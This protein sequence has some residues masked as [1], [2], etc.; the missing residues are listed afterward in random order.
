MKITNS[1]L[2]DYIYRNTDSRT[3]SRANSIIVKTIEF[4]ED[5][6]FAKAKVK[7]SRLY[8]VCFYGLQTGMISSSCTCPFDWGN[9][10]KH[11]V[12]LANE[13]DIFLNDLKKRKTS[14]LPTTP[15][16]KK[17]I[18]TDGVFEYSF[19]EIKNL[20]KEVLL[21]NSIYQIITQANIN[22]VHD[23]I[24]KNTKIEMEISGDS[25]FRSTTYLSTIK[26]LEN[27]IKIKSKCN[28]KKSRLCK[29]QVSALL[30]MH[31]YL[32]HLLV[33]K[34]EEDQKKKKLLS[35]YGFTLEDKKYKQY[36]KFKKSIEEGLK[37]IP[38]KEGITKKF[39]FSELDYL[40]D[41]LHS[42]E[43]TFRNQLP[44]L[45]K[46]QK[47]KKPQAIA[48]AFEFM[49]LEEER[50]DVVLYPLLGNV[51]KDRT[52][53]TTKI[54]N[55]DTDDFLIYKETFNEEEI[56]L[57]EQSFFLTE[58]Y[59]DSINS[60][61]FR[62]PN[63]VHHQLNEFIP[64]LENQIV[65]EWEENYDNKFTKHYLE[66]IHLSLNSAALELTVSEE[67]DF[68]VTEAY[69]VVEGKKE[70]LK[71][72]RIGHNYL[73]VKKDANYYLNKSI[74]FCMTLNF[75]REQPII[76]TIKSDF[77]NFYNKILLPL[78]EKH[79]ITFDY[80]KMKNTKTSSVQ[81]KTEKF[82]KQIYLSEVDDFIVLKP[83]IEYEDEHIP[84][85]S[86]KDFTKTENGMTTI[87]VRDQ[88]FEEQFKT[89]LKES[90]TKFKNQYTDFFFL[91]QEEFI[92]DTW[93]INAFEFFK[94]KEIEV[95]GFKNLNL[96]YNQHKPTISINVSS[97]I[98][99]FD[100]NI[101]VAFGKQIV[102]LKDLK[103]NIINKDK[104][105]RLKDNS[106]GILPEEWMKKYTHLFRSGDVKKDSI[107]VSKYQ[108][109]VVDT[110]YEEYENEHNIFDDHI[111]IKEK[112]KNFK[113]IESIAKPRG[114]KA[115]LRDYQNEGLKWLN[116]LD[117]FNLGGCLADD[118]GLGKTLQIISFIKHL[119]TKRKDKIPHLI[120]V[121]TSLIFNW[122]EEV[123]K[124]CPSLKIKVLTGINREK[125][126]SS[127]K[128]FDIVLS[129]YGIVMNDISYLKE[130]KFNYIILD[131][132]QAIK[133][134]VSK[135]FKAVRLLKAKNRLVLTGTP[136]ENNTFDLYAQ[137]TFVNPGLLGGIQHFKNEYSTAI[138]KNKDKDAA[139]ELKNLI[140]PFLLRRTK[141]Q[142]A[143]ELP[144]KTEQFLYCTM[145]EEQRKLYEAYKNKYKDYLLG[146][147]EDDGLG[148]SK[149][150]V[151][152]GLTKLRQICDSPSLLNDEETYTNQSIKNYKDK[153]SELAVSLT[154]TN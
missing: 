109:S 6:E 75:F 151:L 143:K 153:Y 119:K 118:M 86:K 88:E 150:Y 34:E 40:S 116:F 45:N 5:K 98:D 90:H 112:L 117:D 22:Y 85:F 139:K 99:W 51:N 127:F 129:T 102:N 142:V 26:F 126:T 66:P 56:S 123:D 89:E 43:E 84:L 134:P 132:S 49:L 10:C 87:I 15:K 140:D 96:K 64:K 20:T 138:D 36:F 52:A 11:E 100:V 54:K 8:E 76:R 21:K 106:I 148:K 44:Y 69:I 4:S 71:D 61:E 62:S 30:Y 145:K 97:D 1:N 37:I 135:R 41:R 144:P 16:E 105:I 31:R 32:S 27:S 63:F 108:F 33:T 72:A 70:K 57:I 137:M 53:L 18:V 154:L 29:H 65:Y 111:K 28:C 147:I 146:K 74:D 39:E 110:L 67:K 55:I 50:P 59:L 17:P 92:D 141:E 107:G 14:K 78:E 93:F 46:Q 83:V 152:E 35:E 82:H 104:Y 115:T 128:N 121:P 81:V 130:Y 79:K 77:D 131:E 136:I 42:E 101:V 47:E 133:N 68:F 19:D 58:S 38:I 113:A 23:V 73:F 91:S 13:I 149:M 120:I 25:W 125:D 103:K 122:Q 24:F 80:K 114:V 12:A 95:F 2:K 3:R 9:V 94:E 48:F 7:G 124:F 60:E